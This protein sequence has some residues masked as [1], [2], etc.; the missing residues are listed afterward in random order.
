MSPADSLLVLERYGL[1]I[2]PALMVAEQFGIPLPAVPALLGFGALA[3]HGHG[4]IPLMLGMLALVAL[5]VDFGWYE[6]GR[7]RGIRILAGLCR[8]SLEPDSCVRK[9][10][11]VFA[12]YGA[13]AMLVAKFVPGL[14]T[15]LPPLAGI[16]AIGRVRFALYELA[17]TLLWA[18]VWI[19][20]G[21]MFS[22]AVARIAAGVAKLGLELTLAFG[23]VLGGC[24]LITYLRRRRLFRRLR[25]V[26]PERLKQRLDAGEDITIVD[27]RTPLDVAAVPHAIPGSRWVEA[28][29][30]DQHAAELLRAHDVVLYCS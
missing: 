8:L 18:G 20:T 25:N 29:H 27:V 30:I 12:R 6:V 4:S 17:G 14:T 1:V 23:A 24:I 5:T 3:A 28:D 16:F 26:S 10:Q 21:Y 19:G 2:L 13:R 9:A 11:A 15:I 22:D 7:R